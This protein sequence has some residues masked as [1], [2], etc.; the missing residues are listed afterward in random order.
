MGVVE[1]TENTLH[2]R[3]NRTELDYGSLKQV[4]N[5]ILV[6]NVSWWSTGGC[7]LMEVHGEK[8]HAM[9]PSQVTDKHI[10]QTNC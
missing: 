1:F 6:I 4:S 7:F 10:N 9:C 3:L 8:P 5:N 2:H